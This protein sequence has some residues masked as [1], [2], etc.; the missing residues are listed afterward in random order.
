M[1]VEHLV[2][3][4][5]P[6]PGKWLPKLIFAARICLI[7]V[8][9]Y[10][11]W[12]RNHLCFEQDFGFEGAGIVVAADTFHLPLIVVLEFTSTCAYLFLLRGREEMRVRAPDAVM[13][14]TILDRHGIEIETQENGNNV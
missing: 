5:S 14:A 12:R 4:W 13:K 7:G 9:G 8:A 2:R 10:C 11:V 1:T 3:G 6:W